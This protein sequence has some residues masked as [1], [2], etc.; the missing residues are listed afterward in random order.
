MNKLL[1]YLS[2]TAIGG[3]ALTTGCSKDSGISPV[4]EETAS[5]KEAVIKAV[6]SRSAIPA[7]TAKAPR[8]I[9]QGQAPTVDSSSAPS[10]PAPTQT[11]PTTP[12]SN[13]VSAAELKAHCE[14]YD[15]DFNLI[16]STISNRGRLFIADICENKAL[17]KITP[18]EAVCEFNIMTLPKNDK[19]LAKSTTIHFT[20]PFVM[21]YSGTGHSTITRRTQYFTDSNGLPVDCKEL[22]SVFPESKSLAVHGR[23]ELFPVNSP[24]FVCKSTRT[25]ACTPGTPAETVTREIPVTTEPAELPP[26][27]FF[28]MPRIQEHT[29]KLDV[30]PHASHCDQTRRDFDGNAP[31][32]QK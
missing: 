16:I 32:C 29:R 28:K 26:T 20:L 14:S 11:L 25:T 2:S 17:G 23:K 8:N 5:T 19:D 4:S 21:D 31:G 3:V 27:V 9:R 1:R 18:A 12:E 15:K 24:A 30:T 13:I 10:S 7:Q 6:A 22:S